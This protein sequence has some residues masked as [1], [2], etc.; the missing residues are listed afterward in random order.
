MNFF[1]ALKKTAA[2]AVAT[3]MLM[4]VGCGKDAA[5]SSSEKTEATTAASA[6]A[7]GKTIVIEL[8]TKAAPITCENFEKLVRSGFYDGLTFH[9]VVDNFMAQGG[10]PLGT[11]MGGSDENIKGEFSANGVEN[12]LSHTR[13]VI[14]MA[15]SQD[16]DSASSQFFICYSD[17]CTFL[18]GQYAAFGKVTEGMDVVDDF[19]KVPRSMGGDGAV[20]A[21]NSPIV[22]EKVQMLDPAED[23][24]PR[25]QITMN[26]FLADVK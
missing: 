16:P 8:D 9:R 21:P 1:K 15:R 17:D 24:S 18:D 12:P 6:S 22:M 19:L 5:T 13:G 7:S 2:V 4:L 25:V 20:S 14:S 26:D 3:T 11:G 10:D 23:G